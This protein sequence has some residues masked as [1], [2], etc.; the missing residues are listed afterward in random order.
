MSKTIVIQGSKSSSGNS[1]LSYITP[2]LGRILGI[3]ILIVVIIAIAKLLGGNIF[4]ALQGLLGTA[5]AASH[6]LTNQITSCGFAAPPTVSCDSSQKNSCINKQKCSA[7]QCIECTDDNDCEKM[8]DSGYT[9]ASTGMCKAPG[10]PGGLFNN[11]CMIGW[12]FVG[13]L[14]LQMV[15]T[16]G[17]LVTGWAKSKFAKKIEAITGKPALDGVPVEQIVKDAMDKVNEAT[18]KDIKAKQEAKKLP[19]QDSESSTGWRDAAPPDGTGEEISEDA[20]TAKINQARETFRNSYLKDVPRRAIVNSITNEAKNKMATDPEAQNQV[21]EAR[22]QEVAEHN[23]EIDRASEETGG[24][25][26]DSDGVEQAA[27]DILPVGE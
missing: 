14:A 15:T 7:G 22:G 26:I 23:N 18:D 3:V 13:Y 11:G 19:Y 25:S 24:E 16:L 17:V 9:C 2:W 8:Y 4:N 6:A 20:A 12:G 21:T 5:N 10:F 27:E 1:I